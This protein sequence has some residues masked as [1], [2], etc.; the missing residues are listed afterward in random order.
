MCCPRK[1]SAVG[2]SFPWHQSTANTKGLAAYGLTWIAASGT[3]SLA[4]GGVQELV[5]RELLTEEEATRIAAVR[6][7]PQVTTPLFWILSAY[8]ERI[9]N[10]PAL[11]GSKKKEEERKRAQDKKGEGGGDKDKDGAKEE[12]AEG[13]RGGGASSVNRVA[14]KKLERV[15]EAV[16]KMRTGAMDT[17][18]AVSSFGLQPLPI[19]ML[20]SFLIKVCTNQP[21]A[22]SI[23]TSQ[24][25]TLLSCSIVT[26]DSSLCI[27]SSLHLWCFLV[28]GSSTSASSA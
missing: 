1:C 19:V 22:D 7:E 17:L 3:K 5:A 23:W 28:V 4:E 11:N 13:G 8:T 26:T 15:T 24:L 6:P 14:A 20:M 9:V 10:D 16:L 12:E 27:H 18:T 25:A 2:Y 21:T